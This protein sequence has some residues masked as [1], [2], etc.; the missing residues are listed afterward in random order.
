MATAFECCW[1][2]DKGITILS[3]STLDKLQRKNVIE[4]EYIKGKPLMNKYGEDIL[5]LVIDKKDYHIP[6]FITSRETFAFLGFTDA[7]IGVLWQ[8][9]NN[10][11]LPLDNSMVPFRAY[12]FSER[13][14]NWLDDKCNNLTKQ[15]E[16]NNNMD[17]KQLLDAIGFTKDIQSQSLK[18]AYDDEKPK[19]IKLCDQNPQWVIGWAKRY[20]KRRWSILIDMD[21][22]IT[23]KPENIWWSD[24]VI[25]FTEKL[26]DSEIAY[27]TY[28]NE[29]LLNTDLISLKSKNMKSNLHKFKKENTE[30]N[31]TN[32]EDFNETDS[33]DLFKW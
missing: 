33:R 18:I 15:Y 10:F 13:V 3:K 24:I 25:E 4:T 27:S 9:V 26:V 22:N 32:E 7:R 8:Y 29:P 6:K 23:S 5:K 11:D 12:K 2:R 17:S 19:F 21:F 1:P 31:Y 14:F 30:K 20:I 16:N 28:Y